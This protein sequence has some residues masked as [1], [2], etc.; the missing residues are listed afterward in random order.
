MLSP[1]LTDAASLTVQEGLAKGLA[2]RAAGIRL[3]GMGAWTSLTEALARGP[4]T[5]K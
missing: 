3:R 1:G 5:E 2:K 4:I